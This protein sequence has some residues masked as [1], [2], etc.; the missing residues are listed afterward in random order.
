MTP[1]VL[2]RP[3]PPQRRQIDLALQGGGSHGA[4]TWGVLDRLLED[5][6]LEI[7]GISGTSAG[8]M[9]AVALAAGLMEGGRVGARQALR[10]FWTA[11]AAAS[12]FNRL[13][14][15]PFDALYGPLFGPGTPWLTPLQWY[16]A[17]AGQVVSPYQINPLNLNPLREILAEQIDF[18]RV[19][20]CSKTRLFIAAT[21]VRTGELRIFEQPELTEDMVLASA[22][23]PLL[24]QA[25]QIGG[26]PY[27]D[28]GYAGNPS[29][30][31]LIGGTPADDLLLVPINP[32]QRD[33]VPTTARDI[34]DRV[35]EVT[36]NASL[37]KELRTVA[38]LK[39]LTGGEAP[40]ALSPL[41][42]R[43]DALRVHRIAA[44]EALAAFGAQSKLDTRWSFLQQL[45]AIGRAAADR[46]LARHFKD[47]GQ[48]SSVD[49]ARECLDRVP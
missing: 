33:A 23:L 19:R 34:L 17:W 13:P 27:W 29:L 24:F 40:A 28:G 16:A 20:H 22:C 47:L 1:N 41:F 44:D 45:H 35:N 7:A 3:R 5:E 43:I 32:R 4:F 2:P 18:D 6:R 9:N 42:Q 12:P 49:L 15:G 31:P 21:Q 25:M 39:Q 14:S 30:L 46:W 8:A 10:R 26:E 48:R 36:F 37:L 38:L 11:V